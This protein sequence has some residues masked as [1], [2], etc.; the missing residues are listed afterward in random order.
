MIALQ[1]LLLLVLIAF[2][3]ALYVEAT[4]WLSN[5]RNRR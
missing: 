5:W 4:D 1:S 3:V 2:L